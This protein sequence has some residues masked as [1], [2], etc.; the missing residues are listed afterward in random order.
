MVVASNQGRTL[1]LK[2]EKV[3]CEHC[4]RLVHCFA[5]EDI[6]SQQMLARKVCPQHIGKEQKM[7]PQTNCVCRFLWEIE[8]KYT[9]KEIEVLPVVWLLEP[10]GL[11]VYGSTR[12]K[13]KEN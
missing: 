7:K 3:S 6:L 1:R 11:N 9:I 8:K 13:N 10:F 2:R 5:N 12:T 4:L